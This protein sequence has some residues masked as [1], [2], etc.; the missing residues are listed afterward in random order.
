MLLWWVVL[1]CMLGCWSCAVWECRFGL[2]FG[3]FEAF[4][5]VL[6]GIG[7]GGGERVKVRL[8]FC[9][10]C[11]WLFGGCVERLRSRLMPFTKSAFMVIAVVLLLCWGFLHRI[12]LLFSAYIW[13]FQYGDI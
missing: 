4:C 11:V 8:F 2:F 13:I 12:Y 3:R 1:L 7:H 5:C 6:C 9:R 10:W